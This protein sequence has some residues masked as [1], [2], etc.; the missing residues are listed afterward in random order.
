MKKSLV[1]ILGI[2]ILILACIFY[3][4]LSEKPTEGKD[5]NTKSD[6][7]IPGFG[8]DSNSIAI[9]LLD[10]NN[11]IIDQGSTLKVKNNKI[12]YTVS[13]S[14]FIKVE[15]KYALII[16]ENFK[17]VPFT[18]N[19]KSYKVYNFNA[20]E[21]E[22]V[23]FDTTVKAQNNTS[24]IDYILIKKPEY[25][26]DKLDFEK[27][28][29][30]QEIMSLR[31]VVGNNSEIKTPNYIPQKTYKGGPNDTVFISKRKEELEI[32][33]KIK[34]GETMYLSVGNIGN[35]NANYT[36]V[37][38]NNWKQVPIIDKKLVGNVSVKPDERKVYKIKAPLVKEKSNFQVIAIPNTGQ[39][40]PNSYQ[41]FQLQGTIRTVITP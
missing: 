12:V 32:L 5:A 37:A 41:S 35:K 4:S 2:I 16:L 18:V 14:N 13:L 8:K 1:S 6:H 29:T 17:Q 34:T 31:F 15:R 24:E 36:I 23:E 22:T 38:L 27:M 9:G 25:L 11:K 3:F 30:L 7:I 19:G 28:S 40:N 20:K 21:N 39:L 26:L 33:P 10:K